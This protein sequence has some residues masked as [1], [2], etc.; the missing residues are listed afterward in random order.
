[1][2]SLTRPF[3]LATVTLLVFAP[4][5]GTFGVG[6]VGATDGDA[7][8][9]A[10]TA[11]LQEATV[12][13]TVA[14]ETPAGDPVSGATLTADWDGGSAT[15]TTASNG[16]AFLDVPEGATVELSVDHPDYVRNSPV[17]VEDAEEQTVTVDVRQR[18]SLTVS[19]EDTRGDAVDDAQVILRQGGAIVVNGRTNTNGGFSTG[20][21]EQRE[22]GLTVVKEGFFRVQRT[23]TVG[24]GSRE[25]VELERGS[26]TLSFEVVDP[27][28]DPAEP[29]ADAQLT[30]E[31]A[32]TFQTL[33][34][35]EA[36]AQ[37]PVNS[38]LELTVTKEGYGSDTRTVNV[39]ES[40]MTVRVNLSRTPELNV[41]AVNERVLVGERNV[42]TV[43][44]A[45]GD[46]VPDATVSLDGET[47][48][49]TGGD[50]TITV[51]FEE[52]GNHTVVAEADDLTSQPLTIV[53]VRAQTATA[54][55][56]AT[57]TATPTATD[58]PLTTD[59]AETGV[60][61][62]GFTPL[63]AVIAVLAVASLFVGY[64]RRSKR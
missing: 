25:T 37:V 6:L 9:L 31:T 14:V 35:G 20:V 52:A 47:V 45:Y 34:N 19:V 40:A 53:V 10:E 29:V 50:G 18:G 56:T 57:A 38:D 11:T 33:Q 7:R 44:D 21:I 39:R 61:F 2:R 23:I 60:S 63:T 13:L 51:R 59:S 5:T 58:Q 62:P 32:G 4:V 36:T 48:G 55:P 28:F 43:V 15:A 64:S 3:V 26:V 54:T 30:L 8:Q 16:R 46:P 24:D 41:T 49:M 12:T 1:M 17:V 22:Y 27:R 42:V